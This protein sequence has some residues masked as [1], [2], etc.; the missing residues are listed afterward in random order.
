MLKK[1]SNLVNSFWKFD[2]DQ[3]PASSWNDKQDLLKEIEKIQFE[4]LANVRNK[5]SP[6][7]NLLAI[8]ESLSDGEKIIIDN[9][10][11]SLVISE[12]E[13]SK[14][15]IKYITKKDLEND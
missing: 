14:E 13:K 4:E 1:I 2:S 8:L 7:C 12:I 6:M 10:L 9:K 11:Y 15:V 5:L 3:Q